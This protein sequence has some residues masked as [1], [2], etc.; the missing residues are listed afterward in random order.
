[1]ILYIRINIIKSNCSSIE[2]VSST[3]QEEEGIVPVTGTVDDVELEDMVNDEWKSD[4][5]VNYDD[6]QSQE[7]PM[8][9]NF[10]DPSN[11][12][13]M[14]VICTA[15][16]E[17]RPP[18]KCYPIPDDLNPCEDVMGSNW[19]RGSVWIVAFLAIFGNALV[20]VVLLGSG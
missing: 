9:E 2:E 3:S 16:T 8:D 1:M 11:V 7:T 10:H 17:E 14:D 19:L 15:F 12:F 6:E 20:L 13:R 5:E 18:I 4:Q